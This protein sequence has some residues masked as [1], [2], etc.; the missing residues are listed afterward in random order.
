MAT[1]G[2]LHNGGKNVVGL[3]RVELLESFQRFFEGF[4]REGIKIKAVGLGE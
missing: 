2:T 4:L 1:Q 3:E